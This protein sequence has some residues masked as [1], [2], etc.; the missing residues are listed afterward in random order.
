MATVG[1][2]GRHARHRQAAATS[3]LGRALG[4]GRRGR[5]FAVDCEIHAR[6]EALGHMAE[7]SP[8]I[9]SPISA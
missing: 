7:P 5:R 8:R 2:A 3:A 4:R 1:D 9:A 6:G